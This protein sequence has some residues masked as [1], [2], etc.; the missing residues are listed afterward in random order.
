[1][2]PMFRPRKPIKI[3][4]NPLK[5]HGFPL[6]EPKSLPSGFGPRPSPQALQEAPASDTG[7]TGRGAVGKIRRV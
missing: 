4:E 1:M 7:P 3:H 2:V 6:S 5:S